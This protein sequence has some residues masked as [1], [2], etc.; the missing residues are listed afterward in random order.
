MKSYGIAG[1]IVLS[2]LLSGCGC[3][4]RSTDRADFESNESQRR[5][6]AEGAR[7]LREVADRLGVNV[8]DD[9]QPVDMAVDIKLK[10]D[11]ESMPVPVPFDDSVADELKNLMK[12]EEARQFE[13]VQRFLKANR[14]RM[15]FPV[16]DRK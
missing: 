4:P 13:R 10:L 8:A 16:S 11:G 7:Y 5:Q 2:V 12:P 6:D 3:C 1:S 9:R 14:D 15:V